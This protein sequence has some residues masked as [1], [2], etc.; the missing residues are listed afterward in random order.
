MNVNEIPVFRATRQQMSYLNARQTVLARNVANAD[1]P[2]Y[3][4]QDLREPDFKRSLQMASG[5]LAVARTDPM[6]LSGISLGGAGAFKAFSMK[7]ERNPNDNTVNI[8]EQIV[9]VG[10]TG[11]QYQTAATLYKKSIDLFRAALGRSS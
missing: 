4:A 7:N 3:H 5:G 11:S 1:T 9:K 6:H 10:Q 8:E 2:G